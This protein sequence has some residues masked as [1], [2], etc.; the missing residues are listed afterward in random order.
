M[1][2]DQWAFSVKNKAV[3]SRFEYN[4]DYKHNEI[5]YW[6]KNR[7]LHNWMEELYQS[8]GGKDEF[9]MKIVQVLPEDIDRLEEDT[10]SGKIKEYDKGGFFLGKQPFGYYEYFK[11]ILEKDMSG[12]KFKKRLYVIK[13]YILF[14]YLTKK[15]LSLKCVR[16]N[17]NKVLLLILYIPGIAISKKY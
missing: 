3:L 6:C 15:K 10:K 7:F 17:V 2:L 8:L 4:Q 16:N 11:E 9:N 13:H 14:T 5:F 1:G 12:V